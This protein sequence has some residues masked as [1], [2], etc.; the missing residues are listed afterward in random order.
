MNDGEKSDKPIV[1][2][3]DANKGSGQ[4]GPA[5]C[6]EGRGLAKGNPGEQTR[7]LDSAPREPATCAQ[8]DTH[9]LRALLPEAGA[10]CGNAARRDLC[11]GWPE[12]AIPTATVYLFFF[13]ALGASYVKRTWPM[14]HESLQFAHE[15]VTTQRASR[16]GV[17]PQ[18]PH[19]GFIRDLGQDLDPVLLARHLSPEVPGHE[20]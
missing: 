16:V 2:E 20:T 6:L 9:D 11:G 7:F 14:S 8:L 12:R 10:R 15:P 5:E 4:P 3:K 1:P 13:P 17:E 18:P 19:L